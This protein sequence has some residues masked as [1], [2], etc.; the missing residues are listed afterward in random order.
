MNEPTFLS[1][2]ETQLAERYLCDGY[3]VSKVAEEDALY[4]IRNKIVDVV[5]KLLDVETKQPDELLNQIH[6]YVSSEELNQFRVRVIEEINRDKL[7]KPLYFAV[8]K[9][10]LESLVGNELVMQRRVN[11]SIQLPEDETSLLPVHADVWSGN[12][13]FE[14]VV[15]LPLVDC[16]G[17]KTMFILP[18]EA[19][20]EVHQDFRRFQSGS[21]EELFQNIK[22]KLH[23]I[24]IAYGQVLLFNQ[25]LPHG[26][27]VNQ[28]SETR[29]SM[30]CRFK[31]IFS[32]YSDKKFGEY[33]EPITL[34]PASRVGIQYR[35]PGEE[36]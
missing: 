32:P 16:Y 2:S 17:T 36:D 5:K 33:F 7:L 28:E 4:Q 18:P 13:P 26:N 31:T 27:R 22:D 30:N 35:F 6:E 12:S 24:Q 29:W 25:T 10:L 11:L 3:V 23:W 19:T 9:P 21:S 15:W 1:S 8:A 20:K 34:R 14:V